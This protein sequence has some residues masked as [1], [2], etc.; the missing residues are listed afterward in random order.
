VGINFLYWLMTTDRGLLARIA[1][2]VVIFAIL[3]AF[4]LAKRG[5]AA[6]RWR[7][8]LF[9]LAVVAAAVLYGII[10]DNLAVSISPEYFVYGKGIGPS[11]SLRWEACKVGMKAAFS[12]GLIIGATMLIANNPRRGRRQLRYEKLFALL[13]GIFL[14]AATGAVTGAA[15]GWFGGWNWV[16]NDL[17]VIWREGLFRPRPFMLVYGMNLGG[18]AGAGMGTVAVVAY[19]LAEK[20]KSEE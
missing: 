7:E 3:A 19:I 11:G 5:K 2:G 13:S 10:N 4:D 6:T 14:C 1:I 17:A 12:A 16:S 9:L 20:V 15:I 18:Y 8:Y